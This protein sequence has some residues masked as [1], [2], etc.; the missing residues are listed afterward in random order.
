MIKDLLLK[1]S[2]AKERRAYD[3]A[4]NIRDK[5]RQLANIEIDDRNRVWYFA[6]D[7]L[8]TDSKGEVAEEDEDDG[9]S[10]STEEDDAAYTS[11]TNEVPPEINQLQSYS[12]QEGTP[13][14]DDEDYIISRLDRMLEAEKQGDYSTGDAIRAELRIGYNIEVDDK[15]GTWS[16]ESSGLVEGSEVSDNDVNDSIKMEEIVPDKSNLEKLT[17]PMLKE[18]LKEAGLRVGGKKAE[19][20]ERLMSADIC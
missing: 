10:Y 17:V 6:T 1:R 15:S 13:S 14:L 7:T 11:Q 19:L 4:D 9:I 16:I 2:N 5:L 20:I 12:K 3:E 18:K 8:E